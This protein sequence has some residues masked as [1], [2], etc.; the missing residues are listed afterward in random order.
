[1]NLLFLSPHFPPNFYLFCVRLR[2]AGVTV[3][4]LADETW[5][6]LREELKR[7]LTEYRQ[8]EWME[9]DDAVRRGVEHLV[10]KHGKL[11]RIESHNEHWMELEARLRL[12][13]DVP[14]PRP[15]EIQHARRKSRMKL[16]FREAGVPVAAGAIATDR[17]AAADFAATAGYPIIAKP[18]IGVGAAATYKISSDAELR[19]FFEEKGDREYFLEEFVRGTI[20]TYDGLTDQD[21]RIVFDA[22][23][24]YSGGVMEAVNDDLD[25]YYFSQRVIPPDLA[26]F[27]AKIVRAFDVRGRFFH[28]EFFRTPEG[29]LVILEAN[30]RPPG[31]YTMDMFNYANDADLYAGWADIVASNRFG[32][33]CRKP[34]HCCYVSRKQRFGYRHP[35]E[36][37]VQRYAVRIMMHTEMPPVFRQAMGD[38]AY[39]FR[40]K[41]VEEM[42]ETVEFIRERRT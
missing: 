35:H 1:M 2:E 19:A 37:I 28:I 39:I 14:G 6:G 25:L 22:S 27:G 30:L 15:D 41:T 10:A 38:Y 3:L 13:F 8:V 23:H 5:P 21:G 36:E 24:E 11:D 31:G 16:R 32:Q 33:V 42:E 26:G 4:G 12:E 7:A 18:D 17:T 40:T 9:N 29:K 34:Y 20:V